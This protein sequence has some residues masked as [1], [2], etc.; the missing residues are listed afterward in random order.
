MSPNSIILSNL[1]GNLYLFNI[2]QNNPDISI[3]NLEISFTVIP[4]RKKYRDNIISSIF[5]FSEYE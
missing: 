5:C 2:S 3:S 1:F 4:P